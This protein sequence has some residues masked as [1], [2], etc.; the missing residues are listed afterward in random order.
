MPGLVG[1]DA[2]TRPGCNG[3]EARSSP[4][5]HHHCSNQDRGDDQPT[6][7]D[8]QLVGST[9]WCMQL[10][11]AASDA[12]ALGHPRRAGERTFDAP[13]AIAVDCGDRI[14]SSRV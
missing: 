1:T 10:V 14:G 13:D 8:A 4:R 2:A 6:R 11:N 3:A 12:D 5:G 7:L 9:S